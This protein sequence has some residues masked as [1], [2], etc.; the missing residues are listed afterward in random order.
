MFLNY[1]RIYFLIFF[2]EKK[3]L[4]AEDFLSN[5]LKEI[6]VLAVP[7]YTQKNLKYYLFQIS[8]QLV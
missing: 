4:R 7:F 2:N 5:N 3:N 8:L 1:F 6:Y